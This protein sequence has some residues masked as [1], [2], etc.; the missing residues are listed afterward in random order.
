[1]LALAISIPPLATLVIVAHPD[2]E[3]SRITARLTAAIRN[4]EHVTVHDLSAVYP[5]RSVDASREQ[6][7]LREH[8]AIVWQF[9]WHWYSVPGVLAPNPPTGPVGITASPWPNSCAPLKPRPTSAGCR[10]KNP[11]SCTLHPASRPSNWRT[12][13]R[14]TRNCFRVSPPPHAEQPVRESTAKR[15]PTAA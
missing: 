15:S 1:M 5:D 8:D 6:E 4:E 14:T 7:L 12:M 11:W 2:L 3:K 13:Q 10:W 9:P